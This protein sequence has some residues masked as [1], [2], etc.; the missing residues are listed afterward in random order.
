[1]SIL[2]WHESCFKSLNLV[3][4]LERLKVLRLGVKRLGRFLSSVAP[5][6]PKHRRVHPSLACELQSSSFQELDLV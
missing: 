6:L 2:Y 4:T 5:F 1:M 3:L